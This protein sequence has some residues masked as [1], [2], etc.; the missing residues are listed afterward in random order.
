MTILGRYGTVDFQRTLTAPVLLP[1]SAIDTGTNSITLY[2]ETVWTGDAVVLVCVVSGSPAQIE[3]WAHKDELDRVFL[4]NTP[5]GA[6]NNSDLTRIDL[7]AI[8]DAAVILCLKGSPAEHSYLESLLGSIAPALETSLES[9]PVEMAA[10]LAE[11][12][13]LASEVKQQATLTSW[14]FNLSPQVAETSSVGEDFASRIKTGIS[15][16]GT[17]EFVLDLFG[18]TDEQSTETILRFAFLSQRGSEGLVKLMLKPKNPDQPTPD[19]IRGR[20]RSQG[21][22]YLRSKILITGLAF[23]VRGDGVIEGSSDFLSTGPVGPMLIS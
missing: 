19:L 3:G 11:G 7:S 1:Y 12:E 22:L 23:S 17:F 18:S 13:G 21:G 4:H 6:V 20:L 2:S 8:D 14:T 16:S 15:G 9:S 5:F 10:Y